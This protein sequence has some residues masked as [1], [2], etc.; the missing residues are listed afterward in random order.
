MHVATTTIDQKDE[1]FV[2][3]DEEAQSAWYSTQV[4]TTDEMKPDIQYASDAPTLLMGMPWYHNITESSLDFQS[5]AIGLKQGEDF[6]EYVLARGHLRHPL[7]RDEVAQASLTYDQMP[8]DY[9]NPRK[10]QTIWSCMGPE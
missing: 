7:M 6:Q 9:F 2:M 5:C 10:T 1:A 8:I 3:W 4:N